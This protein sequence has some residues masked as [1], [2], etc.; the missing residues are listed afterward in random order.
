M[1]QYLLEMACP[2]SRLVFLSVRHLKVVQ[3]CKTLALNDLEQCFSVLLFGDV[4][5]H[6]MALRVLSWAFGGRGGS[7]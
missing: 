5:Q 1:L 6:H 3:K 4:V 7:I 2:P